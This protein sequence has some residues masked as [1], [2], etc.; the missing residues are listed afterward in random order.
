MSRNLQFAFLGCHNSY[1]ASVTWVNQSGCPHEAPTI[2]HYGLPA[3]FIPSYCKFAETK[4]VYNIR[5]HDCF[6]FFGN[7]TRGVTNNH[8][9]ASAQFIKEIEGLETLGDLNKAHKPPYRAEDLLLSLGPGSGA[10]FA[11][12]YRLKRYR[13]HNLPTDLEGEIQT[14]LGHK[15]YGTIYDVALNSAGGWILQLK[16]G[17]NYK[18]GG[19][20]PDELEQALEAGAERKATVKHLYLNHQNSHDYVLIFT[21]GYVHISLH[22][23]FETELRELISMIFPKREKMRWEYIPSCHCNEHSQRITNALFY[24]HR[25]RFHFQ[26]R[27]FE[28]AL[29][30]MRE[31]YNHASTNAD[32]YDDYCMTLLAVRQKDASP[33]EYY[34][35]GYDTHNAFRNEYAIM[36][37]RVANV[38]V[39]EERIRDVLAQGQLQ[40]Q[41]LRSGWAYSD[42]TPLVAELPAT[43]FELGRRV[44]TYELGNRDSR[45]NLEKETEMLQSKT[46]PGERRSIWNW[47]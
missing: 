13:W 4:Y 37:S 9:P 2:A 34:M 33:E 12:A 21:D 7:W 1:L 20:L 36:R 17:K 24:N 40:L 23:G 3:S 10:F 35:S 41:R 8:T 45:A 11:D 29:T 42:V 5:G 31:A 6:S 28:H 27:D 30:Y 26:R 19:T 32:Y 46:N 25:G 44:R 38:A 47:K 43:R 22:H 18:W 14:E 15:K 16:K 39:L